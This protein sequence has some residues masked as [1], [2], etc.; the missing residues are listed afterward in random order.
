MKPRQM[1]P[2]LKIMRMALCFWSTTAVNSRVTPSSSSGNVV[3]FV[4][5]F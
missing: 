4:F 3:F 2:F 1:L 5:V